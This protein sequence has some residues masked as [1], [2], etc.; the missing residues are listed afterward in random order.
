MLD[1]SFYKT[2]SRTM[3]SSLSSEKNENASELKQLREYKS[4]Y[5]YFYFTTINY[6]S[7]LSSW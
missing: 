3:L 5:E 1:T 6:Y 7:R 4:E 2:F